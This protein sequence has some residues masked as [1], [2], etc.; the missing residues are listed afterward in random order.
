M[1]RYKPLVSK[2]QMFTVGHITVDYQ[3]LLLLGI[4]HYTEL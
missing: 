2:L 3:Y 1:G 4:M